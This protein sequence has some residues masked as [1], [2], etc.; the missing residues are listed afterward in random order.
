MT[1]GMYRIEPPWISIHSVKIGGRFLERYK[2]KSSSGCILWRG[3]LRVQLGLFEHARYLALGKFSKILRI[4][5]ENYSHHH[6]NGNVT[7]GP[8][9][10]SICLIQTY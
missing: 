3:V 6:D 9:W 8:P 10:V 5:M 1:M 4:E 7:I 2:T